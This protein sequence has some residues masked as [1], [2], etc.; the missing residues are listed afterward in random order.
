M[1]GAFRNNFRQQLFCRAIDARERGTVLVPS[2]Y[3]VIASIMAL[4]EG[5]PNMNLTLI[6]TTIKSFSNSIS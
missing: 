3:D 5:C 1:R 2:P 6:T 4:V